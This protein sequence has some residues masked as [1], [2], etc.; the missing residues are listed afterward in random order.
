MFFKVTHKLAALLL[1]SV[2]FLGGAFMSET[3]QQAEAANLDNLLYLDL[4]FGRVVIEMR[5]EIAPKHVARIRELTREGFYDGVRFHRVMDG[6]M[7]QTG[8]PL[9]K[10]LD[11][12]RRWGTGGS[13][14]K[15]PAEF[16]SSRH[17][18]GTV[19]MARAQDP[20]SG[21][22]QF[23]IVL[24][25]TPSLDGQYTVWG[26]VIEGME[27]VDLIEKAPAG[28]RSGAVEEPTIIEKMQ[29]ASDAN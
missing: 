18:R 12:R 25:P 29:V 21:D 3:E 22:S 9:S 14:E 7:A 6:F 4:P 15:L 17:L 16:N 10:D 5:P 27:F 23:F 26:R 2:L 28:S 19:S 13:G 20:N 1:A 8:D 11:E 24:A